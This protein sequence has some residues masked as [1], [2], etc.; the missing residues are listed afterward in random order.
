VLELF[1]IVLPELLNASEH[2][3]LDDVQ[4]FP[5]VSLG[6]SSRTIAELLFREG[7]ILVNETPM[8]KD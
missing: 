5:S 1:P 6:R 2:D 7:A 3:A 4:I 8:I